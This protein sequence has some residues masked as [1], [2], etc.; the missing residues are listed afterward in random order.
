MV[1]VRGG[2]WG[3]VVMAALFHTTSCCALT[4]I[5]EREEH[6][7]NM[8]NPNLRMAFRGNDVGTSCPKWAVEVWG[9]G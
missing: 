4:V 7:G 5:F 9:R 8:T 3:V 2:V 6:W 1:W